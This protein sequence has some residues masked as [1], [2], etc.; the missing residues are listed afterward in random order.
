VDDNTLASLSALAEAATHLGEIH[1]KWKAD[2]EWIGR[3]LTK[4]AEHPEDGHVPIWAR[5]DLVTITRVGNQIDTLE[6][7]VIPAVN[8][9]PAL[10]AELRALRA[11]EVAARTEHFYTDHGWCECG[12]KRRGCKTLRA[13]AALDATREETL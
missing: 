2:L 10:I 13:L 7:T 6:V 12:R 9:L 11:V 5:E 3:T 1:R 4:V 8:A